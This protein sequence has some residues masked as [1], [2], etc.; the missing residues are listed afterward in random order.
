MELQSERTDLPA[1]LERY[2][3]VNHRKLAE[4]HPDGY[5]RV[6]FECTVRV[7]HDAFIGVVH[8]LGL[9]DSVPRAVRIPPVRQL[10]RAE[11]GFVR[12]E[13][14][15]LFGLLAPAGSTAGLTA[16]EISG[17]KQAAIEP[18]KMYGRFRAFLLEPTPHVRVGQLLTYAWEWGFPGLFDVSTAA[19]DSSGYESLGGAESL[20]MEVRFFHTGQDSRYSFASEPRLKVKRVR[21]G[22][23]EEF[24]LEA[25]PRDQ[26]GYVGYRWEV[27]RPRANDIYVAHWRNM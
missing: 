17:L 13:P 6:H 23:R 16:S 26:L 11:S 8:Y 10:C 14:Y 7:V 1:V 20:H 4:V 21:E 15:M 5:G 27:G 12:R 18:E 22:K 19:E 3:T 24:D 25:P 9:G 2:E